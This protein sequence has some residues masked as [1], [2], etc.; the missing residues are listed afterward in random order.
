[1]NVKPWIVFR[2]EKSNGDYCELATNQFDRDHPCP[3]PSPG[4]KLVSLTEMAPVNPK[5]A[6]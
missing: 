4:Y 6:A 2:F 5:D 1:M 3:A